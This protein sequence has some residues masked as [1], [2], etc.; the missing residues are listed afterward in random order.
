MVFYAI[1]KRNRK[2][3]GYLCK[4]NDILAYICG[5]CDIEYDSSRDLE[6]HML[7]HEPKKKIDAS[8]MQIDGEE[9]LAENNSAAIDEEERENVPEDDNLLQ[10]IQLTEC[11]VRL[12]RFDEEAIN[13]SI[14]AIKLKY[15]EINSMDN[16]SNDDDDETSMSE[17]D[18][19]KKML[20]GSVKK[21]RD[22]SKIIHKFKCASCSASF[23]NDN[24]LKRHM[25]IA[26]V[27]FVCYLCGSKFKTNSELNAHQQSHQDRSISPVFPCAI[28]GKNVKNLKKHLREHK[29]GQQQELLISEFVDVNAVI[30]D[31]LEPN[32]T[33]SHPEQNSDVPLEVNSTGPHEFTDVPFEANQNAQEIDGII[34]S[35]T[36]ID[37]QMLSSTSLMYHVNGSRL[38]TSTINP[39][40]IECELEKINEVT[41]KHETKNATIND[42]IDEIYSCTVCPKQFSS[43]MLLT[44][45][46]DEHDPPKSECIVCGKRLTVKYIPTHIKKYHSEQGS[47]IISTKKK[48]QKLETQPETPVFDLVTDEAPIYDISFQ[49]ND[50]LENE[51]LNL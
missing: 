48:R 35:D 34:G 13:K 26:H 24:R 17:S 25:N 50:D 6:M 49:V 9:I 47:S 12:F 36:S 28:C 33:D 29:Q 18:S 40:A 39:S 46:M 1:D 32:S 51:S 30:E 3:L 11:S 44:Q 23:P 37:S 15:N 22:S 19:P 2:I 38:S 21:A 42:A 10:R 45:H 43:H 16:N 31:E 7:E 20:N 5:E 4:N 27:N 14:S 41:N 8:Q